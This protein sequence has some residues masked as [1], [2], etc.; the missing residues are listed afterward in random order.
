MTTTVG[1]NL[2]KKTKASMIENRESKYNEM[3]SS[4]SEQFSSRS[5]VIDIPIS[6]I[7]PVVLPTKPLQISQRIVFVFILGIFF[8]LLLLAFYDPFD[9]Q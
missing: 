7:Q 8:C 3:R 9:T 5:V 6:N 1:R 2:G 4:V